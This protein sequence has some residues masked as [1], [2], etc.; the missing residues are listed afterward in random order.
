MVLGFSNS[1]QVQVV[2]QA[3]VHRVQLLLIQ[4]LLVILIEMNPLGKFILFLRLHVAHRRQL[5]V[6]Q[7][8]QGVSMGPGHSP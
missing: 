3:D 1:T 5:H 8:R 4:H 6:I 7:L 2:G